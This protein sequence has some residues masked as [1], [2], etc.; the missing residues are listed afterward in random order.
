[1]AHCERSQ[2][3][4]MAKF[5]GITLRAEQINDYTFARN[6]QDKEFNS[7]SDQVLLDMCLDHDQTIKFRKKFNNI[8]TEL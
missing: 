7:Q 1:M 2:A 3:E 6:C 8:F 4:G 5:A